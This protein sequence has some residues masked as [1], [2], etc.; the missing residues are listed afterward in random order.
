MPAQVLFDMH[1]LRKG[2]TPWN[3]VCLAYLSIFTAFWLWNLVE[4]LQELQGAAAM[5]SFT[6]NKLGLSERQLRIITWPEVA[7][8]VVQVSARPWPCS[9]ACC[10]DVCRPTVLVLISSHS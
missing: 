2:P 9:Q 6:T 1:P 4:A 3:A 5:H 8:R 10:L 7:H